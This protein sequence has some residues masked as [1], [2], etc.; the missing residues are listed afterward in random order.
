MIKGIGHVPL[1]RLVVSSNAIVGVDWR[2]HVSAAGELSRLAGGCYC[3]GLV[4]SCRCW[5]VLELVQPVAVG[6]AG[7]RRR[8][9]LW[10][11]R[12][13]GRT[14][15][16]VTAWSFVGA[17]QGSSKLASREGWSVISR[18][19]STWVGAWQLGLGKG[20]Y[21]LRTEGLSAV[22]AM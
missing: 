22:H 5:H 16:M 13:S 2:W 21:A 17:S 12:W 1:V 10:D 20:A 6:L 15:C 3:Q 4:Y 9:V 14:G 8:D 19:W 11:G 7:V 18:A